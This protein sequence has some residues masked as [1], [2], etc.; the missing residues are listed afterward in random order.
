[1]P[2]T[3]SQ[4]RK[5]RGKDIVNIKPISRKYYPVD[6]RDSL[7]PVWYNAPFDNLDYGEACIDAQFPDISKYFK[8]HRGRYIKEKGIK[9]GVSPIGF[10]KKVKKYIYVDEHKID[11]SNA[12]TL[13]FRI[14]KEKMIAERGYYVKRSPDHPK[15]KFFLRRLQRFRLEKARRKQ[16]RLRAKKNKDNRI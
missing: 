6:Y 7:N 12:Q 4:L 9:R 3:R 14:R 16:A 10:K 15:Y 1:M 8:I 11:E 5:K 2:I 13:R